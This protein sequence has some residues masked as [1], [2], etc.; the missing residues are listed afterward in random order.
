MKEKYIV[1]GIVILG[2]IIAFFLG[3]LIG[4][5]TQKVK[6]DGQLLI[7]TIEDRDRFEF[8]FNTELEDLQ[9]QKV[10][11][12]EIVHPQNLQL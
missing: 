12:M 6:Y 1:L 8:I 5:K 3:V 11:T 9:K 10:L 7:G 4:K 2:F